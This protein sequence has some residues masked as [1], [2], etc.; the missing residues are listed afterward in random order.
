MITWVSS[1]VLSMSDKVVE[2]TVVREWINYSYFG[3]GV[4]ERT[5]VDFERSVENSNKPFEIRI[6]LIF[7]FDLWNSNQIIEWNSKQILI[8]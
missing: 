3:I 6:S 5:L 2:M 4:N 8:E 7:E 1:I